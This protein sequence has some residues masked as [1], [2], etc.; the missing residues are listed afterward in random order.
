M[1][2]MTRFH[3][4]N[5]QLRDTNER[6][7]PRAGRA[8]PHH[9]TWRRTMWTNVSPDRTVPTRAAAASPTRPQP[10]SS[11]MAAMTALM[12]RIAVERP[13][14]RYPRFSPCR[15]ACGRP[16]IPMSA[17]FSTRRLAA[18]RTTQ[19]SS[20]VACTSS[21]EIHA[22]TRPMPRTSGRNSAQTLTAVP[23]CCR[24]RSASSDDWPWATTHFRASPGLPPA[25]VAWPTRRWSTCQ[26]PK[27]PA[28]RYRSIRGAS[29]SW[30][31]IRA[32]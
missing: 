26:A 4:R 24:L 19:T 10:A 17:T 22:S 25:G 15:T 28:P 5:H 29:S 31:V 1:A 27:P 8:M 11:V 21:G 7:A 6:I 2:C 18:A 13:S 23:T 32:P 16:A 3:R 30:M 14:L 12:K 20:P 9:G